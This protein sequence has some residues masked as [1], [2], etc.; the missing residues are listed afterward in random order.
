MISERYIEVFAL[1][2]FAVACDI[3]AEI[4]IIFYFLQPYFILGERSC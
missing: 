4:R 3:G 2:A 1:R